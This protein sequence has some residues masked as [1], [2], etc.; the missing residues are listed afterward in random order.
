[1]HAHTTL[2]SACISDGEAG[3]GLVGAAALAQVLPAVLGAVA[4]VLEAVAGT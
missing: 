4:K 2:T 3:E 1:M